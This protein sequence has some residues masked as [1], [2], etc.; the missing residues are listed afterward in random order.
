MLGDVPMLGALPTALLYW[1]RLTVP[2]IAPGFLARL[3]ENV[4]FLVSEGEAE[5]WLVKERNELDL[6]ADIPRFVNDFAARIRE[7]KQRLNE[8]WSV[9]S[10]TGGQGDLTAYLPREASSHS[11]GAN[12]TQVLEMTLREA[13]P[14]PPPGTPF[15][16][17]ITFKR[18]RADNL[19]EMHQAIEELA[20]TLSGAE[21]LDDAVRAGQRRITNALCELDS[22]FG[23][24]WPRRLVGT[25]RANIGSITVGAAVGA[26]GAGQASVPLMIT[27][28]ALAAGQLMVAALLDDGAA[29]VLLPE[30]SAP[31]VYAYQAQREFAPPSV[32]NN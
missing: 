25:L 10:P 26:F 30:R 8:T 23:E 11:R 20:V 9:I 14:M 7:K 13:L 15:Q 1:D 27:G 17:V 19:V 28:G 29:R 18:K 12:H 32:G 31:Y 21:S 6:D 16:D 3:D 2:L 24:S 5:P 4:D 22:V